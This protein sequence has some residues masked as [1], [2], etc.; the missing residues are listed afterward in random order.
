VVKGSRRKGNVKGKGAEQGGG[1]VQRVIKEGKGCYKGEIRRKRRKAGGKRNENG[2]EVE[3]GECVSG[4]RQ[5]ELGK[6]F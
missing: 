6:A 4:R 1:C 2:K 3:K 5:K